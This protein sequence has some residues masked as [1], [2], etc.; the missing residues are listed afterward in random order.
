MAFMGV[1][2]SWLIFARKSLFSRTA[3]AAARAVREKSDFLANMSHEIRTPMNA[4]LGFSDLLSRE[5]NSDERHRSY[6]KSIYESGL[7]LL[8]LVNDILDLSKIDA[9]KVA[10]QP[11]PTDIREIA[12]LLHSLYSQ[13]AS[14]KGI[15]IAVS[16][17]HL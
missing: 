14:T 11:E 5:I 16:Y 9:G 2:I 13:Q 4:I 1:R 8:H 7:S 3:L 17:T 10:L 15:A 12:E 6:A